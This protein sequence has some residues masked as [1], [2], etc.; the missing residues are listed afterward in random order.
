VLPKYTFD[1]N[2][3]GKLHDDVESRNFPK[4]TYLSRR[5]P[6]RKEYKMET[7]NPDKLK[8]IERGR[9]EFERT[10]EFRNKVEEIRKDVTAKYLPTLSNEANWLGR[11][12]IKV[13]I[14][15]EKGKRI[16]ALSSPKNLHAVNH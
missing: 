6:T 3:P 8:L 16:R 5:T 12:F 2:F 11:L 10:N 1:S 13:K 9:D 7:S 14:V 15:I 4:F